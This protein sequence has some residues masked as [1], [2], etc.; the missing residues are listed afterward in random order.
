MAE[1]V[2]RMKWMTRSMSTAPDHDGDGDLQAKLMSEI[3]DLATTWARAPHQLSG[4][5]VDATEVACA[6][7]GIMVVKNG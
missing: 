3:R 7:R 2:R 5:H 6:R 1:A 4:K